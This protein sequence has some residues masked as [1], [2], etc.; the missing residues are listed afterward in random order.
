MN[1]QRHII[2][3]PSIDELTDAFDLPID[4]PE[5]GEDWGLVASGNENVR[6]EFV[7]TDEV[8]KVS[9]EEY[10][11]L[12]EEYPAE[13]YTFDNPTKEVLKIGSNAVFDLKHGRTPLEGIND[14]PKSVAA[15]F[16]MRAHRGI[17][18][19]PN[20]PETSNEGSAVHK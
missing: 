1:Q 5:N 13:L 11:R 20:T 7:F 9:Q 4:K 8:I 17:I 2:Y 14:L 16:A 6:I 15:V 12:Y 10:K 19:W 3:V 18:D